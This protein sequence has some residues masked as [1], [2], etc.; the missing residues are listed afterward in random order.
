MSGTGDPLLRQRLIVTRHGL[1]TAAYR[2]RGLEGS[3]RDAQLFSKLRSG[4]GQHDRVIREETQ[5]HS[6]RRRGSHHRDQ[7]QGADRERSVFGPQSR[8]RDASNH[9]EVSA[10]K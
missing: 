9:V 1:R 8:R 5:M 10:R 4:K 6:P 7:Q 2:C 3:F